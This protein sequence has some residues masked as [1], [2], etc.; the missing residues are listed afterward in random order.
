MHCAA[1]F[2]SL[3]H[4]EGVGSH[5][6]FTSAVVLCGLAP[7][8]GRP[9]R[10]T[11][12]SGRLHPLSGSAAARGR[13]CRGDQLHKAV[14]VVDGCCGTSFAAVIFCLRLHVRVGVALRGSACS[15][16]IS[17]SSSSRVRRSRRRGPAPGGALRGRCDRC[18]IRSLRRRL[19]F[20][21][22]HEQIVRLVTGRQ[23]HRGQERGRSA[24]PAYSM[25]SGARLRCAGVGVRAVP[26]R[27]RPRP[28]PAPPSA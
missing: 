28:R 19:D 15:S 26:G 17:S 16:P 8:K 11:S 10:Q 18:D 12:A 7:L 20:L 9:Q 24:H 2:S 27:P 22:L 1:S 23:T 5:T 4:L 13:L 14:V 6:T 3:P 25:S 21:S